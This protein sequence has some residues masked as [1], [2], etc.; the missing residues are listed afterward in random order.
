M[1]LYVLEQ[2][3]GSQHKTYPCKG[4]DRPGEIARNLALC[5]G[6]WVGRKAFH[7]KSK[8][9]TCLIRGAR[10]QVYTVFVLWDSQVQTPRY[11]LRVPEETNADS[12]LRRH[13]QG[14]NHI[15][16]YFC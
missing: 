11:G 3:L 10:V 13:P 12:L 2:E 4:S 9:L 8:L 6:L 14:W 16:L 7:E 1:S 15:F 5:L